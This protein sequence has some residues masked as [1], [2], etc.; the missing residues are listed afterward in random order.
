MSTLSSYDSML[1]IKSV[2]GQNRTFRIMPLSEACPYLECIYDPETKILVVIS[3]NKKQSYHM[4]PTL[5]DNGDPIPAKRARSNGKQ[6]REERRLL[7]TYQEYYV[8]T[9]EEIYDFVN[10]VCV[11][12]DFDFKTFV[13][14]PPVMG[15]SSAAGI[16]TDVITQ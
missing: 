11:N 4:L 3:K 8:I 12:K 5:D 13:D 15:A 14:A 1:A 7:D 6:F 9:N 2:W 16:Q 10:K